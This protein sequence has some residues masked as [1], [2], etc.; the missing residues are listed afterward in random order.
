MHCCCRW[1]VQA[2]RKAGR[3]A[4]RQG[5]GPIGCPPAGRPDTRGP[6]PAC[7][8]GTV[9]LDSVVGPL[10]NSFKGRCSFESGGWV[11]GAAGQALG[12]PAGD[13]AAAALAAVFCC[14]GWAAAAILMPGLQVQHATVATAPS[15]T[16]CCLS[17]PP[18]PSCRCGDWQ[19]QDALWILGGRGHVVWAVANKVWCASDDAGLGRKL[20]LPVGTACLPAWPR[21]K[22]PRPA[23]LPCPAPPIPPLPACRAG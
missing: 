8:A 7:C 19:L 12:T 17:S 3:L 16:C 18:L 23:R 9:S 5:R 22:P 14:W 11:G 4:G 10:D 20:L 15:T 1:A 21:H 6:P 2:G 13:P